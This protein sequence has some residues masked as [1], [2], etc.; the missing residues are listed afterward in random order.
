MY[1]GDK[2][3]NKKVSNFRK[4]LKILYKIINTN[5]GNKLIEYN[6]N[7]NKCIIMESS[8]SNFRFYCYDIKNEKE[9]WKFDED[10]TKNREYL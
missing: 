6:I 5:N 7:N 8:A 9:C 4:K 3:K 10:S 1:T 2:N